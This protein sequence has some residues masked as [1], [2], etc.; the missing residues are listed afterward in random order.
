VSVGM[1]MTTLMYCAPFYDEAGRFHSHNPNTTT[2][3]YSCS[4]GHRWSES[5]KPKCWCQE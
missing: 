3:Q 4:N 5:V 2:T 1:S